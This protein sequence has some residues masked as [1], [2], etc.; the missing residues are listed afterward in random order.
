MAVSEAHKRASYKYN[1]NRGSIT[2][3][4]TK[5]ED[6]QIRAA[7][8]ASGDSLQN[9]ILQAVRERMEREQAQAP[10]TEQPSGPAE[11]TPTQGQA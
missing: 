10:G 4:P 5:D 11:D 7:A 6:A 1:S 2:L 3:R 8:A 9:Y